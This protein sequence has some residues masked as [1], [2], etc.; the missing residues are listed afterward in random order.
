MAKVVI[1]DTIARKLDA[2]ETGNKITYD[3]RVPGFGVRVTASGARSFVINYRT[4]GGRERRYTIGRVED[5]R[6]TD[7]RAKAKELRQKVD[8]G[9]DPLQSERDVRAAATVK[10][11]WTWFEESYFPEL[12]PA[13][14]ADYK[15][16]ANMYVLPSLGGMKAADVRQEHIRA[17][18]RGIESPYRANR[19]LAVT[20]KLFAEMIADGGFIGV[21]TNPV[22]HAI[23]ARKR[24]KEAK[25]E[26]P[27]GTEHIAPLLAA[28]AGEQDKQ[29]ANV[30]RL[31]MLTGARRGETLKAQ[32]NQ[33]D[34]DKGFWTKPSHHTK[35]NKEHRIALSGA[36]LTLMK[37]LWNQR[38]QEA[39]SDWVFP[40]G[41]TGA[42]RTELKATWRRVCI[43]AGLVKEETRGERV[44]L[45]PVARL[46]DLRHF[47]ASN[48]VA[49]GAHLTVVQDMLGHTTPDITRRYI[50]TKE[51]A[52]REAANAVGDLFKEGAAQ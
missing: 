26:A 5:W 8:A 13:T 27:L 12:R 44:V 30:I 4:K 18:Y 43:A 14:R 11:A 20:S 45:K 37:Q 48:L 28:L 51:D 10:E 36:A 7:A 1:T 31:L 39:E 46:H 52:Q 24:H 2:P 17:M 35:Q 33:F 21:A 29:G 47:Y 42:H 9:G 23:P 15:R 40:S 34:L 25:R 16:L 32:W 3:A 6:A 19:A 38:D 22:K 41:R 50:K 49:S